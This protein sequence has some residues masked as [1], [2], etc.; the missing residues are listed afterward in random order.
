MLTSIFFLLFMFFY[1]GHNVF[2]ILLGS[3]EYRSPLV[4]GFRNDVEDW[5]L[6]ICGQT[7]GLCDQKCHGDA[8]IQQTQLK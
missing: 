4:D 1:D 7:S 6:S 2:N 5:N 3:E 8:L